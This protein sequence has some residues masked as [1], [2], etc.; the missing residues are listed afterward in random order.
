MH[1]HYTQK[2]NGVGGHK[3]DK[4]WRLWEAMQHN[5]FPY[6]NKFLNKLIWIL[7]IFLSFF[8][9]SNVVQLGPF[10][11]VVPKK[12]KRFLGLLWGYFL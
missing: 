4:E 1:A 3:I 8:L 5:F 7:I 2:F 12:G 10:T 9:P 11:I 6:F